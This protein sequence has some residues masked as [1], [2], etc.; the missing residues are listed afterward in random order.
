[1][2]LIFTAAGLSAQVEQ[3]QLL[4]ARG[5]SRDHYGDYEGA[6]RQFREALA[7]ID[8][9][10]LGD[11]AKATTL[12][13]LAMS[14]DEL[15]QPGEAIHIY[16]RS[17]ALIEKARG[18]ESLDYATVLG[19]LAAD[20][21]HT[22]QLGLAQQMLRETIRIFESHQPVDKVR[23]AI[24][25]SILA[26]IVL[27]TGD[28]REGEELL[29]SCIA[30][31]EKTQGNERQL[32]AAYN[33]LGVLR[34]DQKRHAESIEL[35][36]KGLRV[37]E[38]EYG[39]EHIKLVQTLNNLALA[40]YESGQTLEAGPYLE[41]AIK[42]AENGRHPE[43]PSYGPLLMNYATYLRKTGRAR[44][45]KQYERRGKDLMADYARRNGVRQTVDIAS[46]R[47]R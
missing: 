34:R 13:S 22:G 40:L 29:V 10:K 8:E 15:G 32:P 18:K 25:Q 36:K 37:L 27:A 39:P 16:R 38:D 47:Q 1:M 12:N 14:Y 2:V 45:A 21:S 26:P 3:F 19:N 41:R 9:H 5:I 7:W 4:V 6:I 44:D 46:F 20:Y 42:I 31:L 23:L 33:N 24:S 43:H 28:K 17:L 30:V 11:W 35:F